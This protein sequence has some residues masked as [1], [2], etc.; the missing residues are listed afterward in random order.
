MGRA[1]KDPTKGARASK[2]GWVGV[3]KVERSPLL[4]GSAEGKVSVRASWMRSAKCEGSA[5]L[6]FG[7]RPSW[8]LQKVSALTS[9][10]LRV[11]LRTSRRYLERENRG[12][13][14]MAEAEGGLA[15]SEAI[16]DD[17]EA[18]KSEGPMECS[19]ATVVRTPA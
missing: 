3:L 8:S 11:T 12:R 10:C 17:Y 4:P 13:N 6:V 9:F 7:T 19:R 1:H 18:V 15:V 14:D 16:G 2:I 5:I